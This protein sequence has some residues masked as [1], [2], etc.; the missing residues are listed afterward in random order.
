MIARVLCA[1]LVV[2]ACA[3]CSS[4]GGIAGA[5]AGFATGAITANPVLGVTAGVSVK[6]GFDA[7]GK[8]LARNRSHAEHDARASL[9]G[10]MNPGDTR[11]WDLRHRFPPSEVRG[12]LRVIRLIDT[13]LAMCKEVLFSV[14]EE[15]A[16]ET[17]RAWFSAT[18][19]RDDQGWKWATAEPAV[20]RWRNLQ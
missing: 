12:E 7:A 18:A 15:K 10:D 11:A 1:A 13:P 16:E 4:V 8:R 3:G 6:A 19:C 9:I 17:E 5:I 14:V 20:E 2:C